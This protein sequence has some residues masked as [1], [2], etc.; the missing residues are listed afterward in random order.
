M[1]F[2]RCI[3]LTG[4]LAGLFF[5]F[6]LFRSAGSVMYAHIKERM[7]LHLAGTAMT[8]INFFT[9]IGPAVFLHGLGTLMQ[10]LYPEASRGPQAFAAALWLCKGCLVVAGVLYLFTR[11][12]S[13][14]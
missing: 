1:T 4:Y 5:G 7:P 11:N 2:W 8:G 9:M 6:G 13:E 12:K 10:R 3:L 14:I